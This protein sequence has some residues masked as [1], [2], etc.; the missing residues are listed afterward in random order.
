[1]NAGSDSEGLGWYLRLCISN[2]LSRM[3]NLLF[4][5]MPSSKAL[6]ALVVG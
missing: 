2:Q 4:S 3:P 5:G 1:M 6:D